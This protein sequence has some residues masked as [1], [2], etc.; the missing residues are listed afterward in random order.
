MTSQR[1]TVPD[2]PSRRHSCPDCGRPGDHCL[3]AAIGAVENETEVLILQHPRERRHAFGTAQ[4]AVR[5]LRKARLVVGFPTELAQDVE[6]AREL[7]GCGLLYPHRAARDLAQV[8]A[9]E[10][11]KK[12]VVLDGTWSHARGLYQAI[13]A[14]HPLP[15]FTLPEGLVSGFQIR[16]QPAAHCLSTIEAIDHALRALEPDAV[17][18]D[19]FLRPFEAMQ[20]R[21]VGSMQAGAP[22][23][24]RRKGPPKGPPVPAV[25]TD[26]YG[27]LVVAYGELSTTR[28]GQDRRRLLALSAERP[29][30]GE[31]L[32]F[33]LRPHAESEAHLRYMR[34][35][36]EALRDAVPEEE[37]FAAW[38]AF[39]RPGDVLAAWNHNTLDLLRRELPGPADAIE[40]KAAYCNLRPH[41]GAPEAIA[42]AEGVLSPAEYAARRADWSRAEERLQ[43]A[44]DVV[45]FLREHVR[46]RETDGT[47][48]RSGVA[49][50]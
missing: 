13:R 46:D 48:A 14:L 34:L 29:A 2:A 38:R 12:L 40:L 24:K 20:T 28:P 4:L 49:R 26:A 8:P 6:L 22:R 45:A 11:P 31:R 16:R 23:W 3:C 42:Q 36:S 30:T 21:Q 27:S 9:D 33:V 19:S 5:S 47:S 41:R 18:L 17:G 50:L 35:G 43:S 44:L 10:R 1:P 25:L 15:H 32:R 39:L 7:R 37:V